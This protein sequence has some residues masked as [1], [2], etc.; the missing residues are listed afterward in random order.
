MTRWPRKTRPRTCGLLPR[1]SG[2]GGAGATLLLPRGAA[3]QAGVGGGEA[4]AR[5]WRR[6]VGPHWRARRWRR[7]RA[8]SGAE[9]PALLPRPAVA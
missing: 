5:R 9:G 4:G 1:R 2:A 3:G 8:G 7:G 6:P